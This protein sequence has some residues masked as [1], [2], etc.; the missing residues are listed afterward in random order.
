MV[1]FAAST[2]SQRN[3]RRRRNVNIYVSTSL[4]LSLPLLFL[5][6]DERRVVDIDKKYCGK[7]INKTFLAVMCVPAMYHH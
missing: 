5:A 2:L 1:C 4:P 7:E 6:Q 3:N